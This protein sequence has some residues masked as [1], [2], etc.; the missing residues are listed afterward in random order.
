MGPEILSLHSV[1]NCPQ[2]P[3]NKLRSLPV[4]P[5]SPR[6]AD[7]FGPDLLQFPLKDPEDCK[8]SRNLSYILPKP[9]ASIVNECTQELFPRSVLCEQNPGIV[10]NIQSNR[11]LKI[12]PM[13]M[14]CHVRLNLFCSDQSFVDSDVYVM[15]Y[16]HIP[17]AGIAPNTIVQNLHL[18]HQMSE[19]N[20]EAANIYEYQQ[21]LGEFI[22]VLGPL[23]LT[24]C[25]MLMES[26]TIAERSYL[27]TSHLREPQ[28]FGDFDFSM[29][30]LLDSNSNCDFTDYCSGDPNVES[31]C[32]GLENTPYG[33]SKPSIQTEQDEFLASEYAKLDL[34]PSVDHGD[35]SFLKPMGC[36]PNYGP[37][38]NLSIDPRMLSTPSEPQD[39]K[40]TPGKQRRRSSKL[41]QPTA[42]APK[43]QTSGLKRYKPR[44]SDS[45]TNFPDNANKQVTFVY[46]P[47]MAQIS[48]NKTSRPPQLESPDEYQFVV[49]GCVDGS[50]LYGK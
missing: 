14:Q 49:T 1:K 50:K 17:D 10:D 48:Q 12:T 7:Y 29:S 32:F 42:K 45:N 4:N 16:Q 22:E 5:E 44:W 25:K 46:E 8:V 31:Q 9:A 2:N 11:V 18:N 24:E 3:C 47:A 27:M 23:S 26:M 35:G 33:L 15:P 13:P 30:A 38:E 40:A 6:E 36:D 34:P 28:E 19:M 21:I 41:S 39:T 37:K 20:I 43:G